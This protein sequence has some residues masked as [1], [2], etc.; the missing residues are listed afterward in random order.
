MN[1]FEYVYAVNS[2]ELV[3][4]FKFLLGSDVVLRSTLN[5][6]FH[7]QTSQRTTKPII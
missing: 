5:V 1:R 4:Y 7:K 2:A 6:H 3:L